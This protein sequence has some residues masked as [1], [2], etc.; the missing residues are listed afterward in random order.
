[1]LRAVVLAL[2]AVAVAAGALLVMAGTRGSGIYLLCAGA[3]IVGGTAFER[4]RYRSSAPAAARWERTGERFEDPAT[5]EVMEVHYDRASGA[6]RYV[7]ADGR[8]GGKQ[9]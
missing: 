3:A 9:P 5:G 8:P 2:G 1:M 6:R 7:A 4:W